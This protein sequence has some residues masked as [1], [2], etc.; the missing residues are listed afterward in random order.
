MQ[1]TQDKLRVSTDYKTKY[2]STIQKNYLERLNLCF[3]LVFLFYL[4]I[5][6]DYSVSS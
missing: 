5:E 6:F 1:V 3:A 4:H 2:I